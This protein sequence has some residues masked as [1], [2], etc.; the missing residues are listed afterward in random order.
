M[1]DKYKKRWILI[2]IIWL[3]TTAVFI[4]NFIKI[5]F[6]IKKRRELFSKKIIHTFLKQNSD[7]LKKILR[8]RERLYDHVASQK[9]ALL[10]AQELLNKLSKENGI[11]IEKIEQEQTVSESELELTIRCNGHIRSFLEIISS[12]ALNY[13]Y[14]EIEKLRLW[15]FKDKKGILELKIKYN[16]ILVSS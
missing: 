1:K 14:I 8:E 10:K 6:Y 15:L 16:F 7:V 5:D 2:V 12:L 9:I 11:N 13:P 4:F 3:L